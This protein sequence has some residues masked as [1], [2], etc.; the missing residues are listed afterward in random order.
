MWTFYISVVHNLRA[1]W[2]EDLTFA[3]AS[4]VQK[5]FHLEVLWQVS[6]VEID[7]RHGETGVSAGGVCYCVELKC[8]VV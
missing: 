7:T 4:K 5:L 2:C 3:R 8:A 6:G 1:A